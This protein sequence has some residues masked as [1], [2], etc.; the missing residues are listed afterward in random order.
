[1]PLSLDDT[2]A[3][4]AVGCTYKY[5]NGGPGSPAFLFV[6]RELQEEMSNPIW[7][8]FGQ[9]AQFDFGLTYKPAEGIHRF[10]SGTPPVLSLSAIEP[11]IDLIH[12]AGIDRLR[13]KSERQTEY[14]IQLWQDYLAPLGMQLNTPRDVSHRGSHVSLGHPEGLRIDRALIEEMQVI[15]DFRAPDN[16]RLGVAPLYT[17]FSEIY[18]GVMRLRFVLENRVY[19]KYSREGLEV[20]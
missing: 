20:T 15:P 17:T 5:L 13:A 1:M 6:K 16:I 4:L 9:Q 14:L 8:W 12:E 11:S 3:D 2:Q 7:G 19:D 18:E 10:L